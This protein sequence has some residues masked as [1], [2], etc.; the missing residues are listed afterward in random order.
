MSNRNNNLP[1][2]NNRNSGTRVSQ[3]RVVEEV[4]TNQNTGVQQK[5]FLN[6]FKS[7]MLIWLILIPLVIGALLFLLRPR[8]VLRRDDQGNIIQRDQQQTATGIN[9]QGEVDWSRLLIWTAIISI[10]I[11]ALFWLFRS[12]SKQ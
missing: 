8:F 2:L 9:L 12:F 3:I 7:N 6:A 11:Y 10:A 5:G 4:D 1:F